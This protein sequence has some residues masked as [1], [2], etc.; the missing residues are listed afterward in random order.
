VTGRKRLLD[1][2]NIEVAG[3]FGPLKGKIW[4]IGLMGYGSRRENIA[5]L[6]TALRN[7]LA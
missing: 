4:R 5:L 1:E 6:L 3:G 2:Y 7:V